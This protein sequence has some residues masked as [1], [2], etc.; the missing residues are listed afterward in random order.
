MNMKMMR[1]VI[2]VTGTL[3]IEQYWQPLQHLRRMQRD[4]N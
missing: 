2:T 4:F 3:R 1:N